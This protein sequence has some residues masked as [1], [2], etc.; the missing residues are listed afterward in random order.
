MLTALVTRKDET[1]VLGSHS[2]VF[3]HPEDPLDTCSPRFPEF[4]DFS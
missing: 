1:Q 4:L 2:A 3:G